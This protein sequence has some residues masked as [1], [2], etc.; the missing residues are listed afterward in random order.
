MYLLGGG[1]CMLTAMLYLVTGRSPWHNKL[2]ECL[3][4]YFQIKYLGKSCISWGFKLHNQRGILSSPKGR[5]N[6]GGKKTG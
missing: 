2:E 4:H 3:C 5:C 1:I 6:F